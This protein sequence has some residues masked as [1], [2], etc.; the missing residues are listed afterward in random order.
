MNKEEARKQL[1]DTLKEVEKTKELETEVDEM[2]EPNMT[3]EPKPTVKDVSIDTKETKKVPVALCFVLTAVAVCLVFAIVYNVK[4]AMI[5]NR[6]KQL[7][8]VE[9]YMTELDERKVGKVVVHLDGKNYK[10]LDKLQGKVKAG[11]E[12][13]CTI[14]YDNDTKTTKKVVVF[15]AT[16]KKQ[17]HVK[18]LDKGSYGYIYL[19]VSTEKESVE[20]TQK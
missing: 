12:L 11:D 20:A 5:D 2:L 13:S 7:S 8:D 19:P 3:K 4:S 9:K 14:T 17:T 16:D 6:V 10:D 1:T 15:N 18:Y